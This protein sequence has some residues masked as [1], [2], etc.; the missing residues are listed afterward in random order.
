MVTL[1]GA[2]HR[3]SRCLRGP[4]PLV[5][6]LL[7][8]DWTH[9]DFQSV[10]DSEDEI[11][12]LSRTLL[13]V[14]KVRPGA[15]GRGP[16]SG[17]AQLSSGPQAWVGEGREWAAQ[18]RALLLCLWSLWGPPRPPKRGTCVPMA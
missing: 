6:R 9:K 3:G 16:A 7:F 12:E 11:E 1:R 10:W 4:V 14:A 2:E 8:E 5:P 18:A 17:D 13:L 15:A